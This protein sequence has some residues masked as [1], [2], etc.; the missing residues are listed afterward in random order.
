M[1]ERIG[2]I[3]FLVVKV[4]L[5][6]QMSVCLSVYP[7]PL[8]PH[9]SGLSVRLSIIPIPQPLKCPYAFAIYKP[10]LLVKKYFCSE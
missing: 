7:K 3:F 10:F 1:P 8:C 6:L 2:R 4:P 9:I 5:E